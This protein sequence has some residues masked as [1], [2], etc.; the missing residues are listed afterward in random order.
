MA[1][2]VNHDYGAE[3]TLGLVA[4]TAQ[5]PCRTLAES[6][7]VVAVTGSVTA[8]PVGP[9]V[10]QQARNLVAALEDQGRAA[11]FLVRDRDAKFV[12]PF[13]EVMR[14]TGTRIVRTPVRAPKRTCSPIVLSG[15][16]E[17]S[18]WTGC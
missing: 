9:W 2:A 15:Q 16:R 12:G 5:A 17:P 13:D 7:R 18:A 4:P 3:S 11:R 8:H 10:T 6:G 1:P 14:L